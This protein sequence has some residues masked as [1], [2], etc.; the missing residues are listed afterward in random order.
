MNLNIVLFVAIIREKRRKAIA[1]KIL[2]AF[3]H[4]TCLEGTGLLSSSSCT[5]R[6]VTTI[7]TLKGSFL[8]R[9]LTCLY[10]DWKVVD[11]YKDN[12]PGCRIRLQTLNLL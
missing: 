6:H 1:M 11:L 4:F 10:Y 7:G 2:L 5:Q 3:G 12:L 8:Q 9:I